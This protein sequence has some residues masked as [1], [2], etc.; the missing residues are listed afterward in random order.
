MHDCHLAAPAVEQREETP[1]QLL[2]RSTLLVLLQLL[3]SIQR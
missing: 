1:L 3:C 2:M